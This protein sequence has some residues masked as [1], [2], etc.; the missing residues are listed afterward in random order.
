MRVYQIVS[1]SAGLC[2]VG[3][4][5]LSLRERMLQHMLDLERHERGRK[6]RVSSFA[7]LRH[8]DARIEL[9]EEC[10]DREHLKERERYYIKTL[11]SF[12]CILYFVIY[13]IKST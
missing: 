6:H 5:S 11:D 10:H 13:Y 8:P 7:V 1:D 2:Y 9:L 4:T 12:S 3:A